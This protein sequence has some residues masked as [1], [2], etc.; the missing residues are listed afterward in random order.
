MMDADSSFLIA[1]PGRLWLIWGIPVLALLF[2]ACRRWDRKILSRHF[3]PALLEGLAGSVSPARRRL[4]LFF[5]LASVFF[6]ILALAEPK[7]GVTEQ[8]VRVSG[9]DILILLDVSKSMLASDVAP[10]RLERVKLDIQDMVGVLRGDR[11]GLIAFAGSPVLK[12]PLTTDY[13]FFRKALDRAGPHSVGRGGTFIGDAIRMGI[14][15]FTDRVPHNKVLVLISD[16]ED[17]GSFPMEAAGVAAECGIRIFTVGIGD[18]EVG[19]RIRVDGKFIEDDGKIVW[20]KLNPEELRNI[21]AATGG[22]YIPAG[23]RSV[24]LDR[25]YRQKMSAAEEGGTEE[26]KKK[27]VESRYQLFLAAGLLL[28]ILEGI[29]SDRKKIAARMGRAGRAA[30]GLAIAVLAGAPAFAD[31]FD[32]YNGGR[33]MYAAGEFDSAAA[34]FAEAATG[35]E[36]ELESDAFY[37]LGNARFKL[38]E[39]QKDADLDGAIRSLETALSAYRESLDRRPDMPDAVHNME[40]TRRLMKQLEEKRKQ[41]KK[42]SG[43]KKD[44]QQNQGDTQDSPS[45]SDTSAAQDPSGSERG[46]GPQD[47]GRDFDRRQAEA[48]MKE[49]LKEMEEL[50]QRLF[51]AARRQGIDPEKAQEPPAGA[52]VGGGYKDW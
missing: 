16:G 18:R 27:Y 29:L 2:W 40:L 32:Q 4:K 22:A 26:A 1:H 45:A 50:K 31:P 36:P 35:P 46:G 34:L 48:G 20:T 51:Q 30:A 23:T 43:Q 5:L 42:E 21:A 13:G 39:R 7:W 24:D 47:R 12:C 44:G 9:R 38:A 8:A 52:I 19:S 17:Q 25:I 15:S 33:E 37:N 28:L 11:I 14:E 49:R 10:S 6:F 3:S 41:Q